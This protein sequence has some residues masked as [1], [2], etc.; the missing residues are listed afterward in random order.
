M[1]WF[2]CLIY[3]S[4]LIKFR[5]LASIYLKDGTSVSVAQVQEKRE[6]QAFMRKPL[7]SAWRRE[8]PVFR[9]LTP[10][11]DHL[12]PLFGSAI[13][14]CRNPKIE[15]TLGVLHSLKTAV[16]AYLGNNICFAK[17]SIDVFDEV[18]NEI[19]SEALQAPGFRGS[20]KFH[21]LRKRQNL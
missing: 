20:V 4:L 16:E 15:S 7:H 11:L 5:R 8:S 13:S 6:Y 9:Y 3:Q 1:G 14:V 19:V 2:S 10:I 18:K 12:V 21:L 17:L